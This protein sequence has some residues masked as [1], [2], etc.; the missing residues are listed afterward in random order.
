MSFKLMLILVIAGLAVV[1][2]TQNVAAVDVT[3]LV[4]SISLSRALLI[5]FVLMIGF[6]LGWFLHSYLTYRKSKDESTD[7]A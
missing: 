6:V 1:F 7:A 4:W 3:F 2:I 5:F